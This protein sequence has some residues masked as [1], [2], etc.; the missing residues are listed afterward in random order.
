[1]TMHVDLEREDSP[2]GDTPLQQTVRECLAMIQAISAG[3]FLSA[4]PSCPLDSHRHQIAVALLDIVE[5]RLHGAL[6]ISE[7]VRAG[8][9][10]P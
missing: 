4:L 6:V 2:D 8:F 1:M 7:S 10:G 3:E 9:Q 5:R